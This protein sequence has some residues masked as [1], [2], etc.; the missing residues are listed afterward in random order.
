[1]YRA[2]PSDMPAAY[3][4]ASVVVVPA[5]GGCDSLRRRR[6]PSPGHGDAGHRREY[7]RRS[8][9]RSRAALG[10]GVFAHG[11]SHQAWRC[12]GAGD[13]D[14]PCFEPR[15]QCQRQTLV[16]RQETCGNALFHRARLRRNP[17]SLCGIAARQASKDRQFPAAGGLESL[18]VRLSR[19]PSDLFID[20]APQSTDVSTGSGNRREDHPSDSTRVPGSIC[21]QK[22][23]KPFAVL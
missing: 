2:R 11:L 3:L 10:R 23:T 4:A 5:T 13:G 14:R 1:M 18:G 16:A 8:G 22:E 9:N 15:R 19:P 20:F 12:G 6:H 17:R 7:R 21:L